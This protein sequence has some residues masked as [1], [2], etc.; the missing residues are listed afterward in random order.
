MIL[1]RTIKQAEFIFTVASICIVHSGTVWTRSLV[2][3]LLLA[4][5]PPR[6]FT[7]LSFNFLIIKW[8]IVAASYG[9]SQRK[10]GVGIYF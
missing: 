7:F 1:S 4:L 9:E 6:Q 5:L 2:W 3:T 8:E 10:Q